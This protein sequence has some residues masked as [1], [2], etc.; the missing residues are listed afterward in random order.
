MIS[1]RRRLQ[2]G[3][4]IV[5]LLLAPACH[6][7]DDEK[8]VE[9]VGVTYLFLLDPGLLDQSIPGDPLDPVGRIQAATW[10]LDEATL[11]IGGALVDLR[12]GEPCS[13]K[14]TAFFSPTAEGACAN[15]VV[16]EALG[17]PVDVQLV[18]S[19]A[20]MEVRRARPVYLPPGEDYDV[21]SVQNAVDNCPLVANLDQADGNGDGIGDAC[22]YF[23]PFLG[24]LVDSDADGVPDI[25]DNCAEKV[26]P[27]QADLGGA[28]ALGDDP[29]P[30]NAIG[31]A[32]FEEAAQVLH[33]TQGASFTLLLPPTTLLQLVLG[34]S[35]LTVDFDDQVTLTCNW[36]ARTCALDPDRIAF[37][38]YN[39]LSEARGGC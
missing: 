25:V 38:T 22:S 8:V 36:T 2:L 29:Q 17:Y 12:F 5:L 27:D 26:N 4:I 11:D 23:D 32:C 14:D 1:P 39:T 35:Y 20:A 16:I 28:G 33:P 3:S 21:D 13:F 34:T 19:V 15:G 18:L 37:C 7:E 9:Y 10:S 6:E 31:D 24:Y 30:L